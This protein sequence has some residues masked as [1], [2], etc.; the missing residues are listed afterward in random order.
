M[1][2][3]CGRAA[4]CAAASLAAIAWS[5]RNGALLNYGDAVAHLHIARRVFDSHHPRLTRTGLGVAAA[6]APADAALCAG[7]CA[8]GPTGWPASFPPRWPGSPPARASIAWRGAGCRPAAAALTLAFFALN[9]NLLYLQTTAMTEPLFVCEMIW[10]VVWLVEW[11]AALDRRRSTQ[12]RA[13]RSPGSLLVLVAAIFT[14]Y[15]GWIMALLAWSAMGIV[16]LRRGDALRL[17]QLLDLL[18][19]FWLP[20]RSRGSSTTRWPS[21]TGSNLRADPTRPRPS[22]CAPRTAPG[23]PHP[24][25]HNPWVALLF[26][27]KVCGDGRIR[28]A[29]AMSRWRSACWEPLGAGWRRAGARFTW[30]LLLWLPV[31][32]YAYSVAYGSVP[33]FHSRLVAALLVQH[34][35]RHGTAAGAGAGAGLCG[36]D[37]C[38]PPC[39]SSSRGCALDATRPAALFALVA[40]NAVGTGARAA[41]GVCGRHNESSCAQSCSMKT[42]RRRC[43][44]SWRDCPGGAVLMDTSVHPELVALTGIPL[45]QTIN[46]SD[47]T[48]SRSPCS[49][50]GTCGPGAGFRR[51]RHR[52]GRESASCRAARSG[53]LC[54]QAR[55]VSRPCSNTN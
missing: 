30:A 55:A 47:R 20:R 40:L 53:A 24:G 29:G 31:P 28:R 19:R 44:R 45:R 51:R 37:S 23:P 36:A 27:L 26:Y 18:A 2:S 54:V 41:A 49:A 13:G 48:L 43:G 9:P 17:A 5:W 35:L 6:A 4:C 22:K 16:L 32:F 15:D 1:P 3:N 34:A 8:G 50:G 52:S 10:I 11:Q 46:E 39:A 12:G 14:R 38:S 21:A 33:I 7:L 42:F 25:W